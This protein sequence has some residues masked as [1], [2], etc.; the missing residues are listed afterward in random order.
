MASHPRVGL[1]SVRHLEHH[2]SRSSLY[3]FEDVIMASEAV[4]AIDPKPLP[5]PN[6]WIRRRLKREAL[7]WL[8]SDL[9]PRSFMQPV[10]LAGHYDL[11]VAILQK[12]EDA[13]YLHQ[14]PNWRRHCS[15]AACWLDEIWASKIEKYP[16]QL[17]L[18]Q[19]FDYI[20]VGFESTV[21]ILTQRTGARCIHLAPASDCLR[22]CPYPNA[23]ARSI[24]VYS[25]GRRA[26][27]THRMLLDLARTGQI[28]YLYDTAPLGPVGEPMEHRR[29]LASL[30][31]RSNFFLVA[32]AKINEPTQ[33]FGQTEVGTRYYEGAAGGA[34]LVGERPSLPAFDR[35][36]DWP[37]AVV[38]L[39]F[40][41][42][43]MSVFDIIK[44][45]D[46]VRAIQRANVVNCLRRHDWAHRWRDMLTALGLSVSPQTNDRILQMD[47]LADEIAGQRRP[48]SR[49]NLLIS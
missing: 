24:D 38:R 8:R 10:T 39:P 36:F 4:E 9:M 49:P 40:D 27:R 12:E 13:R 14:I 7:R 19:G 37:D 15:I 28:F 22:F 47:E 2:V 43:D 17:E 33:T 32:P 6:S 21:P 31:Q 3:E 5:A 25:M 48:T 46:R 16:K 26:P 41:S 23:P 20:F 45:T 1:F 29:L 18:L 34:I 11:L 42:E 35:D 30:V 44:D